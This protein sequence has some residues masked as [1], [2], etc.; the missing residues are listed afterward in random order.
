MFRFLCF[1]FSGVGDGKYFNQLT[2]L[3]PLNFVFE[4]PTSS[5]MSFNTHQILHY[6]THTT[7]HI[8]PYLVF[9][10]MKTHP[11]TAK[12]KDS[13]QNSLWHKDKDSVKIQSRVNDCA[14]RVAEKFFFIYLLSV[15]KCK[16]LNLGFQVHQWNYRKKGTEKS[17]RFSKIKMYYKRTWQSQRRNVDGQVGYGV[18]LLQYCR[19][20]KYLNKR[21]QLPASN[22]MKYVGFS[23]TTSHFPSSRGLKFNAVNVWSSANL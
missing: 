20:K 21:Y 10:G 8:Y 4:Y 6:W 15:V 1:G 17:H 5:S 7:R 12:I 22:F 14:K 9:H 13:V 11:E 19:I 18:L 23:I 2:K 3:I 16:D